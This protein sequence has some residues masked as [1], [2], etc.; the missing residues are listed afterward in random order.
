LFNLISELTGGIRLAVVELET[1]ERVTRRSRWWSSMAGA[2]KAPANGDA[3]IADDEEAA[4]A[5]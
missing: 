5:G 2:T 4:A 1:A 3:A